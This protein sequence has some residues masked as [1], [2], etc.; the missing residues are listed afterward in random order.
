MVEIALKEVQGLTAP[1]H[2]HTLASTVSSMIIVTLTPV[3]MAV[4]ALYLVTL[5]NATAKDQ[6]V[7]D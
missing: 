3:R 7:Q 6:M 4:V 5:T 2:Q 1:A